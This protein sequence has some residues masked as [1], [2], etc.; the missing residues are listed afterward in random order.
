[1]RQVRKAQKK[2]SYKPCRK[3]LETLGVEGRILIKYNLVVRTIFAWL[4]MACRLE[5]VFKGVKNF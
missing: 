1:M 2:F 5:A 3:S 4:K